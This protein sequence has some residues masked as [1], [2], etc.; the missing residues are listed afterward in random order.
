MEASWHTAGKRRDWCDDVIFPEDYKAVGIKDRQHPGEPV[1]FST[2]YLISLEEPALY[3]VSSSGQGFMRHLDSLRLIASGNEIAEYPE[4]INT[5]DRAMLIRLAYDLCIGGIDTV[6]FKGPDEHII[7][8]HQPDL[9]QILT[10]DILDVAPPN[11]PWLIYVI[12]NL[13]R[14]GVI[15]D[16]TVQFRPKV[17]ELKKFDCDSVYYPCRASGLGRSLDSDKVTHE[18]PR[19]VGCEVSREIFLATNPGK[20]YEFINMCP[21]SSLHP[22]GPFIA[23]CCKSERRG[24]IKRDGHQGIVVH[25]GDGPHEISEAIRCLVGTV[26]KLQ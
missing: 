24:L 16:L 19:I 3:E 2:K 10:V 21:L 4:K 13:E 12:G 22:E 20:D 17:L 8:V 5:R 15:G 9:G 11:P 26:R 7:F 23:R 1:Y 25:W 14:C 6:L 18:K